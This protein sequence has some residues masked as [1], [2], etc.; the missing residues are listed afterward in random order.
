MHGSARTRA[1]ARG[2]AGSTLAG[3]LLLA[4]C[5]APDAQDGAGPG[6]GSEVRQRPRSVVPYW[7]DPR[8]NAAR[9]ART[10]AADGDSAR[11]R[12]LR[13]IAGQPVADWLGPDDPRG[14]AARVTE[15]ATAADREALLVL[16]NVPHRDC[17]Q[18]SKGG[19]ESAAAYRGWLDEVAKGI[20]SRAATVIVEPDALAHTVSGA[21][22]APKLRAE[23]YRLLADAVARLKRLP[24]TTVYLDAGNPDWV[25]DPGALAE[26]LTRAGIDKADGFALNVSNFQTTASN[27]AHGKRLSAKVGGKHF[28]VDTSRNGNGPLHGGEESWCNPPGRA[29]GE[30]PTTRTGHDLVDAYLWIKRPGESDGECRGGPKAGTWWPEYALELARNADGQDGQDGQRS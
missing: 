14:H 1:R 7:V 2:A 28:V 30:A 15:S 13:K 19:A 12:E 17:G 18:Y 24:S 20:G 9:Q 8:G 22:A 27:V 23:R 5:S 26:P 6:A 3:A 21:C 29:L 16:Y 25:R 11:A 10:D 4:G